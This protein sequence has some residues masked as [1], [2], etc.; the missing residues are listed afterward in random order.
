MEPKKKYVIDTILSCVAGA[1][2]RAQH[3]DQL[4]ND[5][6]IE[7]FLSDVETRTLQAYRSRDS[8][9]RILGQPQTHTCTHA[10]TQ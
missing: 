7:K 5:P 9:V 4:A 1:S 3:V 6:A 2:G 10:R 8:E